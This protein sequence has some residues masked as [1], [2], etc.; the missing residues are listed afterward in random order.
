ML[1]LWLGIGLGSL[2]AQGSQREVDTLFVAQADTF[3]LSQVDLVPGSLV[4]RS[5]EGSKMVDPSPQ[6]NHSKGKLW[7][8]ADVILPDTLICTYRYFPSLPTEQVSIRDVATLQDTARGITIAAPEQRDERKKLLREEG[9]GLRKSGSLSTGIQAGNNRGPAITS[10]LRLQLEGDLGDG[11]KVVG[12]LTDENLPIQPDGTTQQLSDFDKVFI[13]LQKD[14]YEVTLGDF[15]I[16][17]KGSRFGNFYRNVQGLQF[18]HNT[19]T[20]SLR[21]S[22]AVAKGRFQTNTFP[23]IDGISGPYRLQGRNGEQFFIVL[24]GSERVYLNGKL[25]KRGEANDYVINYN[26]A[27]ITFTARHVITNITRIV[28]DFEYTDQNFNR[29]LMVGEWEKRLLDDRLRVSFSYARDADNPNAPFSDANLFELVRDSLSRVGD[30]GESVLTSGVFQVGYEEGE[31]RYEQR[32]TLIDGQEYIFYRRSVNPETAI[33]RLVFSRVGQGLGNYVRDNTD[34]EFV[35]KWVPPGPDGTPQGDSEPL[36]RWVLPKLLQVGTARLQFQATKYL[37]LQQEVALS[38]NDQNRLSDLQ[39]ADN[40]DGASR[41]D[42]IWKAVPI[43]DSLW[44]N[45]TVSHQYVGQRY[46]NLDRIYQAEYNR[47]WNIDDLNDRRNEQIFQAKAELDIRRSLKLGWESGLRNTGPGRQDLRQVVS[48]QSFMPKFLQGDLRYTL[49]TNQRDS[50]NQRVAWNRLEGDV[51]AP[52]RLLRPGIEVWME[53]QTRQQTRI[54]QEGSFR[55]FD[56]KPYI[57]TVDNDRLKVDLSFNLRQDQAFL[58]GQMRDKSLAYTAYLQAIAKPVKGLL[59][60]T[61]TS[62]RILNVQDSL[63]ETT[64]LKDS[65]V[66]N[67]QFQAN[68]APANRLVFSSIVYEVNAEQLARQEVRFIEV[69]PGQGTHV[70]LDSLFNNDGIQDIEEFQIANNPLLADFIRILVPTADLVP[71]TRLGLSGNVRW[72]FSQ[73]LADS[74]FWRKAVRSIQPITTF[75]VNQNKRQNTRFSSFFINPSNPFSDTSLLN[76]A[77]TFRQ[78]LFLFQGNP[79]GN[80]NLNYTDNQTQLFLSTGRERRGGAAYGMLA[81]LQLGGSVKQSSSLELELQQGT[82]FL[83][84]ENFSSR[85]YRIFFQEIQPRYNVQ[86][87]RALRLSGGYGY[88]F[89]ENRDTTGIGS[90]TNIS[91]RVFFTGRWNLSGFN[92]LNAR[93]ELVY[94]TE[95]GEP[96]QVAQ[97]ELRQGLQPGGNALWQLISTFRILEDVELSLTY[98]GRVSATGAPLHTGRVQVRAFF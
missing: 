39:D 71:T 41:T 59:L 10:G 2:Q 57:R 95:T 9:N 45:A 35:Y 78:D 52:T 25:M 66:L 65:R 76:A 37:T 28:V 85:N 48:L 92:N 24:A 38:L 20:S 13:R 32:D 29:S 19:A 8:P 83:T 96:S 77:Y 49:I 27:E 30:A 50:L 46:T 75:R 70:W 98:D 22:G 81:R 88:Q 3:Q 33:F 7:F 16:S 67:T 56:L 55:F 68:F 60:Q 12:A 87:S 26:T 97:Y 86:L 84:A 40:L 72:Q 64:G 15:E 47:I 11:L 54:T 36:R 89:R 34:N 14:P 82:R 58:Q 94:M 1:A 90:A 62:Y 79:L 42:L 80:I 63:F 91:H 21:L 61:T 44:L 18:A 17:R 53:D 93:L 51:Y 69:A 4:L 43:G 31:I 23:G 5:L 74:G 73:V 6:V